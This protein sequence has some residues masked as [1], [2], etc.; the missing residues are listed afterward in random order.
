MQKFNYDYGILDNFL[1][2]NINEYNKLKKLNKYA[3]SPKV[4]EIMFIFNEFTNELYSLIVMEHIQGITLQKYKDKKGKLDVH[5]KQKI[6]DKITKLHKLGI[7]HSDLHFE[8]II[9]VK[10]GKNYDFIFI[11]FGLAKS[12]KNMKNKAKNMD[13]A[14]LK[15]N[16][17]SFGPK[18][19]EKNKKLYIA[20]AKIV[21]NGA[22]D[23]I[24]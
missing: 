23:I 13:I 8:N 2:S 7:Y 24:I 10:K 11:D 1:E 3:F 6:N 9:A 15:N 12:E 14:I 22:I 17:S 16:F 18:N 21:N 4:Y 5:D 19:N 20:L